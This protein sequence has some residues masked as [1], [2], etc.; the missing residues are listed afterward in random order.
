[1]IKA[2]LSD[3]EL[4]DLALGDSPYIVTQL[5]LGSPVVRRVVRNRALANGT[6]DNSRFTAAR[7]ITV[8]IGLDDRPCEGHPNMQALLDTILPYMSAQRRPTLRWRLPGGTAEREAVVSGATWPFDLNGKRGQTLVLGFV[9]PDGKVV[10][11]GGPICVPI[12]PSL[13]T[14]GGRVYP[15]V[16]TD[17]GRGP[18]VASGSIGSRTI[19][20][21]G[22]APADWTL[23]M[24]GATTNPTFLINGIP[25]SFTRM[26]GLEIVGGQSVVIDTVAKTALL[27]GEAQSSVYPYMN[28]DQWTWDDLKLRPRENKVRFSAT[29]LSLASTG[30]L[31]YVPTWE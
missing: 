10:S 22:S 14:E 8:S 20:N 17:G 19:T 16:Y 5:Q 11:A 18:Y 3:P 31:C 25:V 15:E 2:V 29:A 23:T 30:L 4:G 27:N 9:C 12:T 13:D 6:F 21:L 28:F 1:M 7:A 26:G 24:F